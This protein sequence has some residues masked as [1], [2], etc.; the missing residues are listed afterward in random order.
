[1]RLMHLLVRFLLLLPIAVMLWSLSLPAYIDSLLLLMIL[2]VVFIAPLAGLVLVSLSLVVALVSCE[3]FLSFSHSTVKSFYREHEKYVRGDVYESSVVTRIE[4][5]HGDLVTIDPTVPST[6]REPRSV[7][8]VTDSRGYRNR[9]EYDGQKDILLGDSFVVANGTTQQDSLPEV[10]NE[11]CGIAAYSLAHP[12]DPVDYEDRAGWFLSEVSEN[13]RLSFFFYEGNDF[14]FP[15][16]KETGEHASAGRFFRLLDTYDAWRL[17]VL[18]GL[19]PRLSYPS[20]FYKLGRQAER[21][22]FS[23][24]G[25]AV[26]IHNVAN[27]PAGFLPAH[28]LPVLEKEAELEINQVPWIWERASCVF[29]IP[30]KA[31]VYPDGF[32]SSLKQKLVEEPA[33]LRRLHKIFD[34]LH[35]PVVDLTPVLRDAAKT[36]AAEGQMVFWRDDTHWNGRGVRAVAPAVAECL[37]KRADQVGSAPVRRPRAVEINGSLRVGN[38]DFPLQQSRSGY[39]DRIEDG[40]KYW[41]ITGWTAD[42]SGPVRIMAVSD[43]MLVGESL[44]RIKRSDVAA[45]LGDHALKSGF[46]VRFP[47]AYMEPG[48]DL[49]VY[50]ISPAGEAWLL[51]SSGSIRS[52]E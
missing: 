16:F 44:T 14:T 50:A 20:I 24:P 39:V 13:V 31:R 38:S 17:K 28:T 29:F 10:L 32:E 26:L 52:S 5:P 2:V 48:H 3:V 33:A 30:T 43:G 34:H 51:D 22:I 37:G 45:L 42:P 4:M 27:A 41:T 36:F 12:A 21:R 18:Q 9:R 6:V 1:M 23:R 46:Q 11:C 49:S 15:S 8:F 7:E 40:K 47:R 25:E 19:F 35:I